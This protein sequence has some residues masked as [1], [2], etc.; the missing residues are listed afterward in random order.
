[1]AEQSLTSALPPSLSCAAGKVVH[2]S[3]SL[4]LTWR[5]ASFPLASAKREAAAGGGRSTGKRLEGGPRGESRLFLCRK[6]EKRM[7]CDAS[8]ASRACTLLR[9]ACESFQPGLPFSP[10]AFRLRAAERLGLMC[11]QRQSKSP[12]GVSQGFSPPLLSFAARSVGGPR[13]LWIAFAFSPFPFSWMFL[14]ERNQEHQKEL[15]SF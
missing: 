9:I 2:V 14:L 4:S 5:R 6:G 7:L 11:S 15:Q 8:W 10:S 12:Q 3:G 1:M 13:R